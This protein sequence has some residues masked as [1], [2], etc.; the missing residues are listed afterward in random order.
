MEEQIIRPIRRR[1]RKSPWELF[2]EQYLPSLI[3]LAAIVVI[4]IMML[5]AMT[6]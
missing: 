2:K 5:G 1:R 3:L 6:A 4:L